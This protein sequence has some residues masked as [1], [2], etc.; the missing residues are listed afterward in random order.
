MIG[1]E[2]RTQ[3]KTI[4]WVAPSNCGLLPIHTGGNSYKLILEKA[5]VRAY[6]K[7]L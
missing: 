4:P 5:E 3:G 1:R 7:V 2:G 6:H